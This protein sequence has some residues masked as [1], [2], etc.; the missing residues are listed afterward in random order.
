MDIMDFNYE[1][2]KPGEFDIIWASPCCRLFS[3]LQNTWI[4]RKWKNKEEI[5]EARKKD[6]KYVLRV[7][8]IIN[9]L[10]PNEWFIENPNS[11]AMWDIPQL[12]DL[13]YVICDYCCFGYDYRK[14][15]RFLTNKIL[16]NKTCKCESKN[17]EK[18]HKSRIGNF[19]TQ[20]TTLAER[21]RIPPDCIKYLFG[22]KT[23]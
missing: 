8:E 20:D 5:I 22:I 15:T 21:Y 12:K 1:Q 16:E 10:K 6:S 11:S 18:K 14:S 7:L 2:F 3:I 9:Y 23:L 19:G 4:G 13:N 17:G